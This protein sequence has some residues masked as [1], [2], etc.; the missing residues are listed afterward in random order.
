MNGCGCALLCLASIAFP[1]I[2]LIYLIVRLY[3]SDKVSRDRH[4]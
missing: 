1:P 3:A 2:P 4:N